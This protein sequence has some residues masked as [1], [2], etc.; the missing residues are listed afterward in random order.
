M[1]THQWQRDGYTIDTDPQRLDVERIHAFLTDSYWAKGT[2]LEEVQRAIAHSLPFGVYGDAE[3]VG[4]ARVV[5]DWTRFAYV[6]DVFVLEEH[7]GRGLGQWLMATL[8]E[9]PE[10]R[11]VW[12]WHL[13]TADAHGLYRKVGFDAPARPERLMERLG[14]RLAATS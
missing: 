1:T 4:F 2:T 3:Q 12:R 11:D 6:A 13:G 14:P 9:H 7:R 8:L 10:L 5:S